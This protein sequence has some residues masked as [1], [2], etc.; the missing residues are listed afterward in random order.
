MTGIKQD[1]KG[2]RKQAHM[3][4]FFRTYRTRMDL[5][6][7]MTQCHFVMSLTIGCTGLKRKTRNAKCCHAEPVLEH[8]G[9][10]GKQARKHLRR[11]RVWAT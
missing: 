9:Q 11:S 5:E 2:V 3:Q 4:G 8:A 7:A 10:Q 1:D 6:V